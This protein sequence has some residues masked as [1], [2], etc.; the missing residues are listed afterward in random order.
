MDRFVVLLE[1]ES[2]RNLLLALVHTLWQG[3]L[4]AGVLFLYLRRTPA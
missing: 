3:A 4:A 1:G 2:C